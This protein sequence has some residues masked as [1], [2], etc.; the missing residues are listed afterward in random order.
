MRPLALLCLL[1]GL[2]PALAADVPGKGKAPAF[3]APAT[4]L[5]PTVK[6]LGDKGDKDGLDY[7]VY[8]PADYE[9][10]KAKLWPLVIFLHGSGERGSDVQLV[11]KTGLT[12]TL[13][14][15]GATPYVMIAPQCPLGG[16]W[17]TTALDKLLDQATGDYRVD[18]KR[19]VLTG[20]SM[21]GYGTWKW[22]AEHP[23]RFAAMIP[24]CG[25][26]KPESVANLK[27]MPIWGF[28]GDADT[29]VKLSAGQAM[30]D[31]SKKAGADVKFTIYPGV[32]H[33]S[34][35]KAYAEPEL[36]GWILSKRK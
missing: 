14:Q 13:E 28:H 33:N 24:V 12:Q 3:V 18:K 8:L 7:L 35:G 2:L 11:R 4:K 19:V 29:A 17:N 21:G 30:I 25:G 23:E 15:R 22:G 16:G 9:Q 6:R 34:W 31:A 1:A 20:L 32:G 10:D 27:G 26:G 36:E 5:P